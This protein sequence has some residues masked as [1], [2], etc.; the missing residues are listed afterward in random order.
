MFFMVE[1]LRREEGTRLSSIS[2][3]T[4]LG[5]SSLILGK[6][7][8][9]GVIAAVTIL[10][11]FATCAVLL[12]IQGTVPLDVR[13]YALVYGLLLGPVVLIWSTFVAMIY[14]FTGNRFTTYA[15][16]IGA[17]IA[18]A[19]QLGLGKMSWV[20]NWSLGGALHWSDIAP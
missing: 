13:P 9:N 5:K 1:S 15:I 4:P 8:A 18:S 10:A 20:W 16:S 3:A 2:Y 11:V 6:V 17:L 19:I 12:I 7:L 14:A